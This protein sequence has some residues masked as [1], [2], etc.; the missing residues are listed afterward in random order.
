SGGAGMKRPRLRLLRRDARLVVLDLAHPALRDAHQR[1]QLSAAQLGVPSAGAQALSEL[2][3][4]AV[5]AQVQLLVPPARI[6]AG[7]GVGVLVPLRGAGISV[8]R[9]WSCGTAN[10][11]IR[12]R[13]SR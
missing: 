7:R 6:P 13:R 9:Y 11:V 12:C 10:G 4:C 5:S 8:S 3:A 1:G 2:R